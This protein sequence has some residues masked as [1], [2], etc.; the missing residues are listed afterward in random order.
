MGLGGALIWTGLAYNLKQRYPDKQIIFVYKRSLRDFVLR[1]P[2]PD[3]LVYKNSKDIGCVLDQIIW[4]LRKRKFHENDVIVVDM[5]NPDYLYWERDTES[6]GPG[7][8]RPSAR[9]KMAG[10]RP[11][12]WDVRIYHGEPVRRKYHLKNEWS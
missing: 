9:E 1:K 8:A 11:G 10:S 7:I 4:R 12:F 2:H 6:G 5:D 3:H